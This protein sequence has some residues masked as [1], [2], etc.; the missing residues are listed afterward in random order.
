M[1]KNAFMSV[2]LTAQAFQKMVSLSLEV[3][4]R[5]TFPGV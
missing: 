2:I 3:I 1:L 5:F 4:D